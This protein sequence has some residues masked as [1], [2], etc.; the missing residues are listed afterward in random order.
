MYVNRLRDASIR[1][2]LDWFL[3]VSARLGPILGP[4]PILAFPTRSVRTAAVFCAGKHDLPD[5]GCDQGR[6][7]VVTEE[8]WLFLS[9]EG[10]TFGISPKRNVAI[11]LD[12]PETGLPRA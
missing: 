9:P 4:L 11:K 12:Y 6:G 7:S 1:S 3:R 8:R 10:L 2:C 5:I